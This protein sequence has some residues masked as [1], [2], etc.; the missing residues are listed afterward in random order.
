MPL[1][2]AVILF[3]IAMGLYS[4]AVFAHVR[5]KTVSKR[6]L[7]VFGFGVAVDLSA[8]ALTI[9]AVGG[10]TTT[11]HSLLGFFALGLM[12]AHWVL[13]IITHPKAKS[14]PLHYISLVIWMVWMTSYATGFISGVSRLA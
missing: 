7:S 9:Y 12:F 5:T 10:I 11:A 6:L 3:T 14:I 4:V 8:T 1:L 2:T 13:F